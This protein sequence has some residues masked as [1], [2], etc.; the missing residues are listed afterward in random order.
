M[1][2]KQEPNKKSML[3][4]FK[5]KL[6]TMTGALAMMNVLAHAKV[7]AGESDAQD[8]LIK[9]S[10]IVASDPTTGGLFTSLQKIVYL[11][12]GVGGLWGVL[13]IVIGGML[14]A[15]SGSNAQKRS[16]GMGALAVA[17]I[18]LF[19]IYKAYDIAGWAIKIGGE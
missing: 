9:G 14:L 17:A 3:T 18:G 8:A 11:V 1:E 15:G 5:G 19:I 2:I 16:G 6:A 12:M 10:G 7:F 4:T 13:W